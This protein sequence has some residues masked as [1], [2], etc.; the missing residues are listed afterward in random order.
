[1]KPRGNSPRRWILVKRPRPNWTRTREALAAK[2]QELLRKTAEHD[3]LSAAHEDLSQHASALQAT[4]ETTAA[5]LE[6]ARARYH[7]V[8]AARQETYARVEHLEER[9]RTLAGFPRRGATPSR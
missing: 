8:E 7:A 2:H 1:M 3:A 5:N 4:L 9:D 6:N